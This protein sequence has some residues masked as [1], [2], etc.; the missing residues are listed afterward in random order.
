MLLDVLE[1]SSTHLV[2]AKSSFSGEESSFS[3][4]KIFISVYKRTLWIIA[5]G[6]PV[7]PLENMT[8]RGALKGT[9]SKL[10]D[11]SSPSAGWTIVSSKLTSWP[12]EV[13]TVTT[14]NLSGL[15]LEI[16][17]GGDYDVWLRVSAACWVAP[18]PRMTQCS[19]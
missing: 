11:R 13:A 3:I 2:A 16:K 9:R 10:R 4:Y 14:S 12:V 8:Y 5:F 17:L 15:S 1:E 19:T 18:G 7:V 6:T